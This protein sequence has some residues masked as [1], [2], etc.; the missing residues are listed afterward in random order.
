M[1]KFQNTYRIP[2]TRLKNW[3]YRWDAAYF[4]TICTK[5]REHYFGEVENEKM[6][7]SF[8]GILA[9]V[10]WHE[11]KNHFLNVELGDFVV[12]PN[13][14]HGIVVLNGNKTTSIE[15]TDNVDI[16]ISVETRHALSLQPDNSLSIKLTG[17]TRFQNQGKNSVSSIIG[18]YKAAVTKHVNRL[19]LSNDFSWQSRF[20]DHIIRNESEFKKIAFYIQNNPTNWEEDKFYN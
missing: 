18:S 15:N 7:Y 9:D 14:V 6:N 13:H 1:E 19:N 4:I 5:G 10:F 20:H 11:I 8:V 16:G 12:M 17:K 3:D 2:S